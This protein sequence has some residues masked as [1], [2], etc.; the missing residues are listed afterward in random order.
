[1]NKSW[2]GI[3]GKVKAKKVANTIQARNPRMMRGL[4]LAALDWAGVQRR[5]EQLEPVADQAKAEL[6]RDRF[7]QPLDLLVLELDHFAGAHIDE[8]VVMTVAGGV[9]AGPAARAELL[10]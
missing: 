9:V 1:M 10:A 7:L 6:A 4:V 3:S 2:R 8:V 5:A